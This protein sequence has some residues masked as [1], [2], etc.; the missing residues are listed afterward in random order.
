VTLSEAWD[1][2]ESSPTWV[3]VRGLGTEKTRS[4]VASVADCI[5][6]R[7]RCSQFLESESVD[8]VNFE[9]WSEMVDPQQC[10]T[11]CTVI[12]LYL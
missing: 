8:V 7:I 12:T 3:H 10:S 6:V 4:M 9:R 2:L 5:R 1:V 11:K